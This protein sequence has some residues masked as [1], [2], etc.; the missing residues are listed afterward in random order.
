MK[1]SKKLLLWVMIVL[2]LILGCGGFY[3]VNYVFETALIR[4]ADQAL[5]ENSILRFAFETAL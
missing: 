5:D 2:A 3:F 1:F 4:E